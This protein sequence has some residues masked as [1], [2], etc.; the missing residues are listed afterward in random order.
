[1]VTMTNGTWR[2]ES[3]QKK[4]RGLSQHLGES[5]SVD[6]LENRVE[7]QGIE[8]RYQ[9]SNYC[10]KGMVKVAYLNSLNSL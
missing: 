10:N 7:G 2:T 4:P 6:V 8:A 5:S 9:L 3:F 1:M